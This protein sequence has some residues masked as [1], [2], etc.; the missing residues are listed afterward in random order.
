[1]YSTSLSLLLSYNP[2]PLGSFIAL[3]KI[4]WSLISQGLT[5]VIEN[6]MYFNK[7]DMELSELS[8]CK[9]DGNAEVQNQI[10]TQGPELIPTTVK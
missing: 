10:L 4:F 8:D 6:S 5:Q 1:M 7:K 2:T 9:T 3:S